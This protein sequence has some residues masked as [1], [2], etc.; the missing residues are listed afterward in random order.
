MITISK[1]DLMELGYGS[2][3]ATNII[4]TAKQN[5]IE[6]GFTFYQ[7]RKLDVVPVE[8]IEEILGITFTYKDNDIVSPLNTKE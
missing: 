6:K 3:F 5:M 1:K 7:S 2:T 8:A 4:R